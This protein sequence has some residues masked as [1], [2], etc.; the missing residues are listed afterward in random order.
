MEFK[1]GVVVADLDEFLPLLDAVKAYDAEQFDYY[2]RKAVR[3]YIDGCQIVCVHCGIG[4]VN[5][6]TAAMYL[7]QNGVNT[8]LN[9]GLSGGVS[10]V[11]RGE[12]VLPDR[13]LEHDFDLTAIGYKPCEKPS[14]KYI[15]DADSYISECILGAIGDLCR[16]TAVCGDRFI[17]NSADRDFLSQ[18]FGATSCDME[19]A[20]IASVCDMADIPFASVRRISDDAGESALESYRD[21]NINE[22]DTL[23]SIFIKCL[24]AVIK[25]IKEK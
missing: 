8:V 24:I 5:A 18:T 2:N 4:K 20:A 14:Q 1:I 25:G 3:F 9:Y 13:F 10:G 19:T 6:A 22:G 16:G 12:I 23:S 21:M 11:R 7:I 15:Y 17:C